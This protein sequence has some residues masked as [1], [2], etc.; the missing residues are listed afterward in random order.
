MI[1]I[2][3]IMAKKSKKKSNKKKQLK[4]KKFLIFSLLLIFMLVAFVLGINAYVKGSVQNKILSVNEASD[5]NADCILILGAG[6]FGQSPSYMLMDRLNQGIELYNLGAS[7]RIIMSGDHGRKDYDEVNVMKEFAIKKNI[8]S[9]HVFMD[10]AGF[11]TY[12]SLFRARDVFLAKRVIIVT[13]EYHLYRA[14]YIAKSL[15][16]EAYGV[17]SDPRQYY[18]QEYRE[19]REIFARN[20]DFIMSIFKPDP[21]FLGEAIPVNGN[22]DLTN[23]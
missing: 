10:H 11:S 6:V 5:L 17:A 23:D 20:K 22:G 14:L 15:G 7:D 19:L 18:G 1:R 16:F 3:K 2:A 21:T 8:P 4:I 9:E 13:Q 12:E